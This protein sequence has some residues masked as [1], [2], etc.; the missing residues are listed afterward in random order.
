MLV[1]I[2]I[3]LV[4][5]LSVETFSGQGSIHPATRL[6]ESIMPETIFSLVELKLG[7]LVSLVLHRRYAQNGGSIGV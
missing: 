4:W 7:Y 1:H 3:D 5:S 2:L 6:F